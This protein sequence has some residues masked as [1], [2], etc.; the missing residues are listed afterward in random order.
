MLG[1]AQWSPTWQ[2]DWMSPAAGQ[3]DVV[4]RPTFTWQPA[5]WAT[6]YEFVLARDA[7]FSNMIVSITTSNTIWGCDRDLEYGTG[8]FWRVRAVSATS[9]SLW[10]SSSFTTMSAPLPPTTTPA[11]V[12]PPPVIER[13]PEV[14]EYPYLPW[15]VVAIVTV[16]FVG[17][18]T[19][20]VVT[21][22]RY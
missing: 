18:I 12:T 8:Y 22:R 2:P 1:A 6:G 9:Q 11:P 21:R 13:Q 3:S 16:L 4:L 17:I 5:D 7:A 20:I 14:D 10:A 19:L 15:I